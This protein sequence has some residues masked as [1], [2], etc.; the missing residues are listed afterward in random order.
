MPKLP[1]AS[2]ESAELASHRRSMDVFLPSA[3]TPDHHR[4]KST[5]ATVL[6]LRPQHLPRGLILPFDGQNG[7]RTTRKVLWPRRERCGVGRFPSVMIGDGRRG[8][9]NVHI[10]SMGSQRG[11]FG[12][13]KGQCK[14]LASMGAPLFKSGALAHAKCY[15]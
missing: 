13:S 14:H 2:S 9:K 11:R 12:G 3:A 7:N 15:S 10:P 8:Q 4:W 1:L 5:N 6:S